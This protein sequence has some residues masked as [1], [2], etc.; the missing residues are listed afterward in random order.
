MKSKNNILKSASTIVMALLLASCWDGEIEFSESQAAK[1][2]LVTFG[3]K[4]GFGIGLREG[5][6]YPGLGAGE[7]LPI[8]HRRANDPV[9]TDI[10]P[11]DL[12]EVP[13]LSISYTIKFKPSYQSIQ[14][15]TLKLFTAGIQDGDT[16][17]Y[18]SDTDIKLFID[19]VELRQVFD[20][21]DQ[22]APINGQ[23]SD[24]ASYVE[25][26]IPS[27]LWPK[28][29]DGEIEILWEILQLNAESSSHDAFA[30]DYC[31]MEI[32]YFNY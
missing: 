8:D 17:V 10:Y 3:D 1:C 12:A 25:L 11:A 13:A 21:T 14:R 30:I 4:D 20:W 9:I 27:Y 22:F 29:T 19:G 18:K 2:T 24:Y 7:A 6:V 26:P 28:L 16:D 5:E 31:D 15:A 32:C 23:W